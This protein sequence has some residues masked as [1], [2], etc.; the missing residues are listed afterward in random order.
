[1][2]VPTVGADVRAV[3]RRVAALVDDGATQQ[4]GIGA[5]PEQ[6]LREL[7]GHRDL[8]IHSGLLSDAAMELLQAGVVTGA[9]KTVD[10]GRAVVGMVAGSSKLFAFV[11]RN[12]DVLL[13]PT[14][15]THDPAV[16]AA[17]H[18]LVAINGALSVDLSGQVNAET[19]GR[20]YV[21][22]VG[23]AP[24]FQRGAAASRGGLPITALASTAHGA[25][26]IVARLDG[27]V[28]T[29]RADVGLVVTEHGVA[30][31]RGLGLTQRA[32]RLI[33]VAHPDHRAGL[34]AD[35]EALLRK[36]APA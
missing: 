32:E 15:Y 1:M 24:A 30:D 11:D 27:P 17:Q 3:A 5:L 28:S 13:A 18:A 26:R 25:S 8:G 31:L 19:V 23:G 9:R 35:L 7:S 21:G 33:A 34:E 10:P 2:P 20:R 29:Q 14:A 12:P 6:V 36:G 16:L 22:A 4:Y